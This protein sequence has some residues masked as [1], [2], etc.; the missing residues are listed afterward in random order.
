MPACVCFCL[1]PS[2]KCVCARGWATVVSLCSLTLKCAL[3]KWRYKQLNRKVILY[4]STFLPV[5]LENLALRCTTLSLASVF[6]MCLTD[7][8]CVAGGSRLAR[9]R[10]GN[11]KE[12]DPKLCRVLMQP[13]P[14]NFLL[15][16]A[17]FS[18]LLT[19]LSGAHNRS[20]AQYILSLSWDCHTYLF[21]LMAR[22]LISLY[23]LP[24]PAK[25]LKCYSQ[26]KFETRHVC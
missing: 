12:G 5:R 7:C 18:L 3:L 14:P 6:I 11:N 1:Q 23:S 21:S 24:M 19:V 22:R 13:P 8:S 26:V 25:A 16:S 4:F 10:Y 9:S 20:T 2:F 17:V 15:A